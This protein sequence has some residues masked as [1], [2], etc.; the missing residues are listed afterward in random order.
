MEKSLAAVAEEFAAKGAKAGGEA[1]AVLEAASMMAQD[2]TLTAG[3]RARHSGRSAKITPGVISGLAG[4]Y[5]EITP[6]VI[7][8]AGGLPPGEI[9]PGVIL[10]PRAISGQPRP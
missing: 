5:G 10:R 1:Q 3:V 8:A 7:S 2:P 4:G 9:T 6:G